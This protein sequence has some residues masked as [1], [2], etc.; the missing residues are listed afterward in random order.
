MPLTVTARAGD[1]EHSVTIDADATVGVLKVSIAEAFSMDDTTFDLHRGGVLQGDDEALVSLNVREGDRI[2]VVLNQRGVAREQ[3]R[4][5]GLVPARGVYD[6]ALFDVCKGN[7]DPERIRLLFQAGARATCR[8]QGTTPLHQAASRN[9]LSAMSALHQNGADISARNTQGETPLHFAVMS[10][11]VPAMQSLK[12]WGSDIH[13][14]TNDGE[15]P[16]HIASLC[17][18]VTAM[19]QLKDWGVRVNDKNAHGRTPLFVAAE[20]GQAQA[21]QLLKSWGARLDDVP[22]EKKCCAVS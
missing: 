21:M 17:G 13:E 12:D 19:Q 16:M 10:G 7:G 18:N 3:L 22:S 5:L 6:T 14:R 1:T 15:T 2:E 20:S 8:R 11:H 4:E 9:L